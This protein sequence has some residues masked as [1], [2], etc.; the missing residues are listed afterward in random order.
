MQPAVLASGARVD[1]PF[2]VLSAVDLLNN[3]HYFLISVCRV[4]TLE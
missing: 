1:A 4:H 3:T 2:Y